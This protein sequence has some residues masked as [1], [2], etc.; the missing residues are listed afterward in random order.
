MMNQSAGGL[1]IDGQLNELYR[2]RL[3]ILVLVGERE[4]MIIQRDGG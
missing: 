1:L 3:L 4:P 2:R